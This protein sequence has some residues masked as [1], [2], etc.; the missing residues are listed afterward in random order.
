MVHMHSM[1]SLSVSM[2]RVAVLE[3]GVYLAALLMSSAMMRTSCWRTPGP[4]PGLSSRSV[5]WVVRWASRCARVSRTVR[6]VPVRGGGGEAAS[7]RRESSPFGG[8][9]GFEAAS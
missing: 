7:R 8:A 9:H 4:M 2:V 6:M 5:P 1:V 3:G